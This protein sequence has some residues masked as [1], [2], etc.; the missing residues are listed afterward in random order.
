M[1]TQLPSFRAIHAAIVAAPPRP[2]GF[3]LPGLHNPDQ[4][5]A[6]RDATHLH[7]F[8]TDMRA[9][10]VRA[11]ATP[12]APLSFGIFRSFESSGDRKVYELAYFDRRRRLLGLALASV[13]DETDAYIPA[14][15]DLIWEI[16]AEYTWA[17]PAHIPLGIAAVQ[18]NRL[19]PEQVVD[20]F[21][22]ETAHA[23][24]EVLVLLGVRLDAW[25]HYRVRAEIERRIFGPLFHDPRHFKWERDPM[26]WAAVCGGG[27]GMAALLLVDDR[28]RLAG[29]VDRVIRAL[30]CFLEGYGDDGGCPEGI[31]YW[32]Y[33]F[34][35]YTYF[36]EMLGAFTGGALDLLVGEHIRRIVAFPGVVSL[37]G[38]AFINYSD[39]A[40]H[41]AIH[42]GLG[43]LLASRFQQIVPALAPPNF[44]GDHAYRWA[45]VTRNLAWIDATQF[46]GAVHDGTFFLPDLA[47]LIDRHSVGGATLA[48]SA[49]GGHNDEP[50]NHN[51]LGHF[52]L[53]VGGESLL[54]DLGAG[55]YTRQYFGPER[56]QAIHTG[57]HGHSVPQIGGQL[58]RAGRE[59]AAT[60]LGY[61][62]QPGGA[63]FALDLTRAYALADLQSFV[64]A[65]EWSLNAAAGAATLRLTDTLRLAAPA[66]LDE[67]FVSRRAPTLE[68][69]MASWRGERGSV[70][71]RFD[72]AQF[73]PKVEAINTQAHLGEPFAA[74][75]L[76]LSARHP[77]ASYEVA[78]EFACQLLA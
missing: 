73:A 9:E 5:R 55:T 54:A 17:L 62:R 4:R 3:P 33:G 19:P 22:A 21:A 41:A 67:C 42:A 47:W 10:A 52:I 69:G 77:A 43:S 66:A 12:L 50:H 23:L 72:Q 59:Y 35:Y 45:H 51:D 75:R 61:E 36:A 63:T 34:G 64:R 32:E 29:M 31:G 48:F 46:G 78:F 53:H 57:S 11:A 56:Y 37:G 70:T 2:A 7:A 39:A 15:H 1:P 49:K 68:P 6:L 16:C 44:H 60:L 26:N 38:D 8:L 28:E 18:A 20:L 14:L 40:E 27:A 30:E 74:Y 76:C 25:L 71:L 65:F 13:V 58:Q 24:A